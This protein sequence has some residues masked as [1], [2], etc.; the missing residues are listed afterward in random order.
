MYI[1]SFNYNNLLTGDGLFFLP[2]LVKPFLKV[3]HKKN[4]KQ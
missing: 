2:L 3:A 4:I 1:K